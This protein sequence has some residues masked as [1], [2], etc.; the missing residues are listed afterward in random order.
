LWI[1]IVYE[2]SRH[3]LLAKHPEVFPTGARWGQLLYDLGI[4]YAGV[5]T[6]YLLSIRLALRRNRRTIYQHLAPLINRVVGEARNL[7][8][9]LNST[10]GFNDSRENSLPN[11]EATCAK[12]TAGRPPVCL[13]QRRRAVLSRRC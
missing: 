5:F 12:I 9:A 11:V 8:G 6:F 2:V 13:C 1:C 3:V 10:A 4:A 7:I